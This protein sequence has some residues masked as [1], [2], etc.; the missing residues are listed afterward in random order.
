V[1]GNIGYGPRVDG[2]VLGLV[3]EGVGRCYPERTN[4]FGT[5]DLVGKTQD[6][7]YAGSL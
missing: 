5:S 4:N 3:V 6:V 7:K 2:R 1:H